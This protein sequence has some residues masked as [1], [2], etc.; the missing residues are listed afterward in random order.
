MPEARF[1]GVDRASDQLF[2][3][4]GPCVIETEEVTLT[5]AEHLAELQDRLKI[6]IIFKAS[7]EKANRSAASSYTGPGLSSGL[8]IL[9]RVRE[10]TGLP[11]L[12]DVHTP[13]QAREAGKVLDALQVP[14]FLCRQT[15]L[16]EAAA[17]SGKPVGIKRGQFMAPED[18]AGAVE[19]GRVVRP[20]GEFWLLERGVTFG[21][22]NLVVD[23]RSFQTF[24]ETGAT[25]IF[26]VTHALQHPGSGGD[27][28][29]ARPLARAALAAGALGLFLET[30]PDPARAK[31]DAT[32]QLPLAGIED[33]LSEM[34][35]WKRLQSEW[36][37]R[38]DT[39][40]SIVS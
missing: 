26:D 9:A 5:I 12:S 4:A 35:A 23:M 13:D 40:G 30:H 7:Y 29:Y 33:F 17:A 34:I 6:P 20:D 27:R 10:K 21:Y 28:R 32:T 24:A 2:I 3:I 38:A 1:L 25:P 16:I 19:K 8:E 22:H 37:D 18:M 36:I 39:V 31:S 11:V 14:A 15:A